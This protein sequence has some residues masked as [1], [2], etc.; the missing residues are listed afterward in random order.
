M[1]CLIFNSH[2]WYNEALENEEWILLLKINNIP[3]IPLL[4]LIHEFKFRNYWNSNMTLIKEDIVREVVRGNNLDQ[5][6]AK[7]LIESLLKIVKGT[8]SSG[9]DVLISGFGLFQVRH[10]RA[11]VGRNPK[12]K[13][14]HEISERR[15]VTFYP[16]RVFRKGM[17]T[18]R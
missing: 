16:S 13:E 11:R 6:K 17:T 1:L 4:L 9:E 10:K 15:V 14:T 5:N 7:N 3:A 18:K 8:L 2:N 12:T